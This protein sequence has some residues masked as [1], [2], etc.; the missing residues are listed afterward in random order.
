MDDSMV[1]S[2]KT[3]NRLGPLKD[4]KDLKFLKSTYVIYRY[5]KSTVVCCAQ[6]KKPLFHTV[7]DA[8]VDQIKY[9]LGILSLAV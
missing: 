3:L 8:T 9:I 2:T 5:Q 1:L 4:I 6:T 7:V